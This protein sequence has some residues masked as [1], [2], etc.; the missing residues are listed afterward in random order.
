MYALAYFDLIKAK[1]ASFLTFMLINFL[2]ADATMYRNLSFVCICFPYEN[3]KKKPSEV[4]YFIKIA[5]FYS[6]ALTAQLAENS[7]ITRF[8]SVN[9]LQ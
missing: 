3:I 2:R 7:K 5:E 4:G 6:T 9:C 1:I 8:I